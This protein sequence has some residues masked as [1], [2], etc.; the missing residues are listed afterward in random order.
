MSNQ[1]KSLTEDD[2]FEGKASCGCSHSPT[3][4]TPRPRRILDPLAGE[5]LVAIEE[6]LVAIEEGDGFAVYGCGPSGCIDRPRPKSLFFEKMKRGAD[7]NLEISERVEAP[8]K[9]SQEVQDAEEGPTCLPWVKIQRDPKR[10]RACLAQ[11]RKFGRITESEKFFDMVKDFMTAEDQEVFYVLLLDTQLQ[12]RG[13]SELAR[14]ARDR[15][16]TPIPDA[17]RVA[18]IDGA[19]A[20]CVAH[21]HPS[22]PCEPSKADREL[23]KDIKAG[24]DAVGI[25]MLDHIVVGAST[26]EYYSFSDAGEL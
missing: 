15:T 26:K 18:I 8:L 5:P 16:L 7:G 10:F 6:P 13:I 25:L 12:V 17:L 22:G 20:F 9:F 24:A 2:L 21:N 3:I 23:T 1:E 14:G 11:A 4:V 19:M